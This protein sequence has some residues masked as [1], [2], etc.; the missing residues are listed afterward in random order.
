MSYLHIAP[1]KVRT[2]M[3]E[4]L[5]NVGAHKLIWGSES[6]M[7]GPPGPFLEAFMDLEIPPELQIDYGYPQI[8]RD[9]KED[10]PGPEHGPAAGHRCAVHGGADMN[11]GPVAQRVLEVSRLLGA[12]A[13]G[14]ELASLDEHG[15]V[16]VRFTG[17]CTG[18]PFR[19][20]TLAATIRPALGDVDRVTSVEAARVR[21]SEHAARRLA[22]LYEP[23]V[24]TH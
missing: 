21:V 19:P 20:V 6:A 23:V 22:A 11:E 8:T 3:G 16:T 9:D 10:D 24:S 17:M 14:I 15:Q 1:R 2:W 13:G 12:H 4:L 7:T 5:Q 18:C